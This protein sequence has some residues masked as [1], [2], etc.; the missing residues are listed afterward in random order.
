MNI[1]WYPGHMTKAK[2]QM[3]DNLKRVDAVLEVLDARIPFSSRNPDFDNIFNNKKRIIVLN[4]ADLADPSL[5][6][7]WIDYFKTMGI[8][9]ID[10]TAIKK[11]DKKRLTA[12]IR[13]SMSEKIERDKKRGIRR[14]VKLMVAG[15]PNSGKSTIINMLSNAASAKT[16]NRPG[17]TKGHQIIRVSD[18]IVLLDTPGVLWPKFDDDNIARNLALTGAIKEQILDTYRL[19]VYLLENSTPKIK[20]LIAKRYGLEKLPVSG[21][22]AIEEIGKKRGMLIK[23]GEVDIGRSTQTI[24]TEF[25][26]GKIGRLTLDTREMFL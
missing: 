3:T 20:G 5:T 18:S 14:D 4:K 16:G 10:I 25:K 8:D 1:Q 21:E 19:A 7:E 26:N 9:S 17:V 22:A 11:N 12:F 23:G 13:M 15:I 2:R 24:L 6:K